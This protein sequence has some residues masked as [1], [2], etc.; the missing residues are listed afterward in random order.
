MKDLPLPE[1]EE[2]HEP[3]NKWAEKIMQT[4]VSEKAVHIFWNENP[5][6]VVKN[7]EWGEIEYTL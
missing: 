3:R 1:V 5:K 6:T 2:L 7:Y 4:A